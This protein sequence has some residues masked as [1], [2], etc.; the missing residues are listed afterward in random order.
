MSP[1]SI[2]YRGPL[3]S[4]N[5]ACTYCP[6][7][8]NPVDREQLRADAEA[9]SRF[10]RHVT[11]TAR[12]ISVFF[13]PWGEALVHRHYQ[14]AIA[15]LLALP[16]VPKVAIQTNLS[17][18]L[19]FLETLDAARLGLWSTWHPKQMSQA[20]FLAQVERARALGAT[21]SV[22]VVGFPDFLT[23][24]EDLRRRLPP[25]VYLWVNAA[26][27]LPEGYTPAQLA[28]LEAVDPVFR[29]NQHPHASLGKACD[30]G[31]TVISVDGDGSVRRCHFVPTLLGNLYTD[32]LE[33]MLRPRACPNAQCRCHIGYVH[34]PEL[35][36]RERFGEGLLE[37][38]LPGFVAGA[39]WAEP[40]PPPE[41]PPSDTETLPPSQRP[42]VR[43]RRHAARPDVSDA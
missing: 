17:A 3:D 16:H 6:F 37:R 19:D 25:D 32:R 30:T 28:R 15:R 18:S 1:L 21:V 2:L 34:V 43:W 24:L 36:L 33:D 42:R 31:E 10:V 13:T 4:C 35:G 39:P 8:K 11:D 41:D 7:A 22:G 5:F 40:A 12:T 23:A 26:R 38:A 29:F 9:L 14:E 20:R 27:S